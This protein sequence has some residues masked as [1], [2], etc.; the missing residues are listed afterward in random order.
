[1]QNKFLRD[2]EYSPSEDTFFIADYIEKEK[3]LSALDVGSGSG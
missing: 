3:G 2:E 1:M